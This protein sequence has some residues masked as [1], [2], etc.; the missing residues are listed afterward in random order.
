MDTT[1]LDLADRDC[2]SC[3]R[4]IPPDTTHKLCPTCM[5]A[6]ALGKSPAESSQPQLQ[7]WGDFQFIEEIGRGGMGVVWRARQVSLDR[8]VALKMILKGGFATDNDRRRF[9]AEAQAAAALNHPNIVPIFEVGEI[10]GH[11]F[12]AMKLVQGGSLAQDPPEGVRKPSDAAA[13]VAGIAKGIHHAHQRGILHRDLKPG[14]ILLENGEPMITDFGLA[15]RMESSVEVTAEG[16][17]LGS[18]GYMSP[19]QAQGLTT[20][21]STATDIYSLGAILYHLLTGRPPFRADSPVS[22]LKLVID[23]DPTAP[24]AINHKVDRDL[25]NICLKCLAKEPSR[26][27]ASADALREDLERW[28]RR[29][30]VLARRAP[31]WERF[32]K[33]ARRH[34]AIAAGI[35][36]VVVTAA[37]GAAAVN[38][39]FQKTLAA[40]DR[41]KA[42]ERA[43]RSARAAL[44]EPERIDRFDDKVSAASLSPDGTR[45]LFAVGTNVFIHDF[46]TGDHLRTL[47][48]H[49][50]FVRLAEWSG[51]GQRILTASTCQQ[52]PLEGSHLERYGDQTARVWDANTG[53]QL[54]VTPSPFVEPISSITIDANGN[55]YGLGSVDG[56]LGVWSISGTNPLFVRQVSTSQVLQAQFSL[57]GSNI[58]AS[59]S[60]DHVWVHRKNPGGGV[61]GWTS[62]SDENLIRSFDLEGKPAANFPTGFS[63]FRRR[64]ASAGLPA[65]PNV[66]SRATFAVSPDGTRL[67]TAAA[68][69]SYNGLWNAATGERLVAL[70][71]LTQSVAHAAFSPD[72]RFI[73]AASSDRTARV[74]DAR[75]GRE[76]VILQPHPREVLR[77][78]FAKDP[79]WLLTVCADNKLR[80]WDVESGIC[81]ALMK[82]HRGRITF[83][84]FSADGEEVISASEDGTARR[85]RWATFEQMAVRVAGHTDAIKSIHFDSDAKRVVTGSAD[86][87]ARV[88]ETS[89]GGLLLSLD[90][91]A[92]LGNLADT[93]RNNQAEQ[94]RDAR[95]T[96]DGSHIITARSDARLSISRNPLSI[97]WPGIFPLKQPPFLPGRIWNI[98]DGKELASVEGAKVAF[99]GVE[100]SPDGQRVLFQG[101]ETPRKAGAIG[102]WPFR[103]YWSSHG[104]IPIAE[105]VLWDLKTKK[106]IA[107]IEAGRSKIRAAAFNP[108]DGRILTATDEKLLVW[109][110]DGADPREVPGAIGCLWTS[111]SADGD[112]I[113]SPDSEDYPALWDAETLKKLRRFEGAGKKAWAAWFAADGT[114]IGTLTE[115][116]QLTIWNAATGTLVWE[117]QGTG[118]NT[119][120]TVVSSDSRWLATVVNEQ[121]IDLW[122]LKARRLV[123]TIERHVYE[124]TAIGFSE[125]GEWL[126]TGDDSGEIWIWPLRLAGR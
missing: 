74:W 110:P 34:P 117:S 12:Y 4:R 55:H 62:F 105:A 25:D 111:Y 29:E 88:M 47:T 17:V 38:T 3:G 89:R 109:S 63:G 8:D 123:R 120:A 60:G 84:D 53:S 92:Y 125:G 86:G 81:V 24:R 71:G 85:W 11:S 35:A 102:G 18:P 26:R 51:D 19:E 76:L 49:T 80:V 33:S 121:H 79:R 107:T 58:L 73:A 52:Q 103:S 9:Q 91:S 67:A 45:I 64:G 48:G 113:A 119:G 14:N 95:F 41:A 56:S 108:I 90:P 112:S 46:D 77:V 2:P 5:L 30:P 21:I 23:T 70:S 93:V 44:I 96:P 101:D 39:Q 83:A 32:W 50:S 116:G 100:F 124:V 28:M 94:M 97:P 57:N 98:E 16:S 82:G 1:Y 6:G 10:D 106:T 40:L 27:Y 66:S 75:S 99:V 78:S 115:A 104:G 68:E 69:P 13:L 114:G 20:E 72:G 126:G 87:T 43:E 37:L 122:D 15:K 54:R 42:N 36:A 22:T 65:N 7:K 31:F 59:S 118:S 61:W